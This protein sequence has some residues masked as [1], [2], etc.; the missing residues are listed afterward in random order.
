[1]PSV[2]ELAKLRDTWP[3]HW[4]DVLPASITCAPEKMYLREA[5][6]DNMRKKYSKIITDPTYDADW[7]RRF[8]IFFALNPM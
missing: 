4:G 6:P 1:M 5:R 7:L 3:E 8:A 2:D